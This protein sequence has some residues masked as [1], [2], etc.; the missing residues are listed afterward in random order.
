MSLS[1]SASTW[2]RPYAK[3]H[4]EGFGYSESGT[5]SACSVDLA[6]TCI[7]FIEG[8]TNVSRPPAAGAWLFK[9]CSCKPG[10]VALY[11]WLNA[12]LTKAEAGS[13]IRPCLPHNQALC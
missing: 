8:H 4:K 12:C 2:P 9:H 7:N 6:W 3:R 1:S 13:M 11:I 10:A 5:T